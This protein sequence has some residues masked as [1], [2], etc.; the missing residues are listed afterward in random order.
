MDNPFYYWLIVPRTNV[1][2]VITGITPIIGP[3]AGGTPIT[4]LAGTSFLP[5]ATVTF[6][7]IPAAGVVFVSSIKLTCV[8]PANAAGPA[9]VVVTNPDGQTSG[10]SG[11][12][13]FTYF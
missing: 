6:D 9:N 8:T 5:G 1:P 10:A 3:I 13:I 12:G 11:N 4:N 2:P 7:G